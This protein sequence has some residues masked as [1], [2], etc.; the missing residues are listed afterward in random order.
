MKAF[1]NRETKAAVPMS[2]RYAAKLLRVD[3]ELAADCLEALSHYG[4]IR[5]VRRG[6]LGANGVGIAT[7]WRLTDEKYL[8][9]SATLDF[10]RWDGVLYEPNS[11]KKPK[12]R[13]EIPDRPVR[14]FRQPRPEIPDRVYENPNKS[15]FE[16]VRKIQTHLKIYPSSTPAVWLEAGGA[17]APTEFGIGHNAG[18]PLNSPV[19]LPELVDDWPN[20]NANAACAGCRPA[21]IDWPAAAAASLDIPTFLLR[22][23]PDCVLG[24]S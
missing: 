23:H 16:P 1:Y 11:R 24:D 3:K 15:H 21:E 8:Q 7:E 4:F 14:I 18:P 10:L 5:E 20:V 6:Y 2:V 19:D 22:G 12:P 17:D 9:R 13:P